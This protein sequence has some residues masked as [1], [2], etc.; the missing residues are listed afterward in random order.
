MFASCCSARG[1]VVAGSSRCR[2]GRV[3]NSVA[4]R[5]C[6]SACL[7]HACVWTFRVAGVGGCGSACLERAC[8]WTFRVAG[9][10]DRGSACL[11]RVCVCRDVS[12]GGR[13]TPDARERLGGRWAVDSLGR[14]G[15]SCVLT[16]LR[17]RFAW[18][19]WGMV[20]IGGGARVDSR[21]R[22]G[23]SYT[24]RALRV[25]SVGNGATQ[26]VAGHRFAWQS[27]CEKS[28]V[29]ARKRGRRREIVAGAGN[30]SIA[31]SGRFAERSG[32]LTWRGAWRRASRNAVGGCEH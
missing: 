12:R 13:G 3:A 7:E 23:E 22:R 14:C 9:V 24:Q 25:V 19:V 21:G 27:L 29:C 28:A 32:R 4:I 11:E 31:W 30:P 6:N 17:V 20:A 10:G 5:R 15:E 1:G 8:V 18:Q 26:R 16:L 2:R